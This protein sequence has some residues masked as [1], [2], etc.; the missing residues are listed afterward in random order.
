MVKELAEVF[1]RHECFFVTNFQGLG[2][3]KLEQLRQSLKA[4]SS[5]YRVVKNSMAKRALID[6]GL[7]PLAKMLEGTCGVGLGG[8]DPIF[9]SKCL[10]KFAGENQTFKILGGYVEGE[11]FPVEKIKE[12]A[13]LPSREVLLAMAFRGMLSSL[14]GLANLLGGVLRSFLCVLEGIS[15]KAEDK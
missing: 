7:E 10:V 4:A 13:E 5:D 3:S 6:S 15:K 14:S 2:V 11:M 1:Q 8:P 12:L 9:T